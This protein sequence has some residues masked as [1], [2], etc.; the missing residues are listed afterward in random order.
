MG[1]AIRSIQRGDRRPLSTRLQNDGSARFMKRRRELRMVAGAT[2]DLTKHGVECDWCASKRER[3][4]R[5]GDMEI[6]VKIEPM[7]RRLEATRGCITAR[8]IK[9]LGGPTGGGEGASKDHLLRKMRLSTSFRKAGKVFKSCFRVETSGGS[10][11]GQ[12]SA[13]GPAPQGAWANQVGRGA[14]KGP[15]GPN[16]PEVP[17]SKGDCPELPG[18]AT[19]FF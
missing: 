8:R 6:A 10:G 19:K 17:G 18:P 11:V 7:R 3:G 5:L 2:R 1:F 4:G 9:A 16:S 14:H 15:Q 12:A 13:P